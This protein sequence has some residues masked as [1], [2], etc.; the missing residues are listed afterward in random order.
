MDN[1]IDQRF[2]TWGTQAGLR[3]YVGSYKSVHK[4]KKN[5][6][7]Q[8]KIVYLGVRRGGKVVNRG[9]AEQENFDLG[10]RKH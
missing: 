9:Y 1:T 6:Q 4:I 3:G 7:N 2:S 5:T 8:H 10:V